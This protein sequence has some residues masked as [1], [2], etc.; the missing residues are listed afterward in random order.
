MK[1]SAA[2]EYLECSVLKGQHFY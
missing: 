2:L 1:L